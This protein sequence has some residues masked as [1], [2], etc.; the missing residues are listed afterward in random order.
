[1]WQRARPE[2]LLLVPFLP[3]PVPA[4]SPPL[5]HTASPSTLHCLFPHVPRSLSTAHYIHCLVHQPSSSSSSHSPSCGLDSLAACF[6]SN[7]I[8]FT[9]CFALFHLHFLLSCPPSPLPLPCLLQNGVLCFTMKLL[10][11]FFFRSYFIVSLVFLFPRSF[12]AWRRFIPL[13]WRLE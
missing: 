6:L 13:L 2:A 5:I 11:C 10:S 8:P 12:A 7:T 3:H 9:S 1:M 4:C